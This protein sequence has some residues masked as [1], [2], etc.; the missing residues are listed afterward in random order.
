MSYFDA[1]V[2]AWEEDG[3]RIPSD[4]LRDAER[5]DT[6]ERGT[7]SAL[8]PLAAR[9]EDQKC[10]CVKNHTPVPIEV[11]LHHIFPRAIQV[12]MF[13]D[14]QDG[15]RVPLCRT[16][17]R[18]VHLALAAMLEG[19]TVPDVNPYTR[20]VAREGFDRITRARAAQNPQ[21][22]AFIPAPDPLAE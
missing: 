11:E 10:K 6:Q 2:N 18:N 22:A 16:A 7:M 20:S 17:H 4:T 1:W 14:V 21:S 3:V 15:E 9:F 19:R 12:D 5:R 8:G 13:G